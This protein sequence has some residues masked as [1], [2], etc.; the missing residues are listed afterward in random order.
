MRPL[1]LALLCLLAVTA[2]GQTGQRQRDYVLH[3]A[4]LRYDTVWVGAQPTQRDTTYDRT[5]AFDTLYWRLRS[6][7]TTAFGTVIG[8]A[9]QNIHWERIPGR[10]DTTKVRVCD[11]VWT[12]T[13][14][15]WQASSVISVGGDTTIYR[16]RHDGPCENC[17][18][19]RK[20]TG[21]I[22]CR[23]S[24]VVTPRAIEFKTKKD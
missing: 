4:D 15:W 16:F 5:A 13:D 8:R 11:T 14:Q 7:D 22:R 2:F 6:K 18:L 20:Q 23:D 17:E 21:S 3:W 19:I 9:Y 24:L 10:L 1:I 12:T